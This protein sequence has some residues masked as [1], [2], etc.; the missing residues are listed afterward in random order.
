[1]GRVGAEVQSGRVDGEWEQLAL[2]RLT[3]VEHEHG[4]DPGLDRQGQAGHGGGDGAPGT[5]AVHD[6]VA[7]D[8]GA[9]G[10]VHMGDLGALD[11]ES[12]DAVG[13]VLDAVAAGPAAE[14]L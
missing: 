5:G 10:Q 13:E 6:P 2:E 4:P 7:A 3:A 14:A 11:A 12:D 9:A 1:V 8:R